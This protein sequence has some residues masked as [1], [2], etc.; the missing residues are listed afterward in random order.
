MS[1]AD[2]PSTMTTHASSE[3]RG[4]WL[5]RSYLNKPDVTVGDNPTTA[6]SLLFGEGIMTFDVDREHALRVGIA[7]GVENGAASPGPLTAIQSRC[8]G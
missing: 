3:I 1:S 6:L 7:A 2:K 8:S 5:Y 4:T